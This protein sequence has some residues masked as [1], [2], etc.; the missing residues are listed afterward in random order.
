MFLYLLYA[1][2]SAKIIRMAT[3]NTLDTT[4]QKEY[5]AELLK[6]RIY[7]TIALLAVLVSIDPEHSDPLRADFLIIGTIV[8]LWAAS[9]LATQMS[10]RIVF[11]GEIDTRADS[12]HQ[13]R[14]HA[15]MLASLVFPVFL[16]T[17][18]MLEI[19][20]LSTAINIAILSTL[21]LMAVWSVVS[22]RELNVNR[23]P[24]IIVVLVELALGL[25][26]VGLKVIIGH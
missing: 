10:R 24:L 16:V 5:I 22:A 9:I 19:I 17:L 6:E 7:A 25:S 4:A 23:I 18:S 26:I 3:E 12:K 11:R 1:H 15:P 2:F 8:S 21:A 20:A 14:K 13:I